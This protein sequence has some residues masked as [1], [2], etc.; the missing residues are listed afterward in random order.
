MSAPVILGSLGG[1]GLIVGP[2]GL[3]WL[4][5]R[6]DGPRGD[7]GQNVMDRGFIDFKRI[8]HF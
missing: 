4:N 8:G 6:R 7:A 1:L 3:L 2:G 5:V